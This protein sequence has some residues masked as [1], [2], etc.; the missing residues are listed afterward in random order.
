MIESIITYLAENYFFI[1]LSITIVFILIKAFETIIKR[2]LLKLH[3]QQLKSNNFAYVL[4]RKIHNIRTEYSSEYDFSFLEHGWKNVPFE[5]RNTQLTENNEA[6]SLLKDRIKH[7]NDYYERI[8]KEIKPEYQDAISIEDINFIQKFVLDESKIVTIIDRLNNRRKNKELDMAFIGDKV[9]LYDY[10]I[11]KD[12][13]TLKCYITDHFT[14]KI[15]KELYLDQTKNEDG[16]ESNND[17]F[18]R[19]F[20]S[21]YQNKD[22]ETVKSL[23]MRTLTYIFS[24]MGVDAIVCGK[25]GKNKN[26]CLI[27]I[28][29]SKIDAQKQSRLHVSI[30]E[31]FSET[32]KN[33]EGE[34]D[35][36]QWIIRGLKEEI[37][38]S[39]KNA[40][41]IIP[42]FSDFSIITDNGE[43]GLC[44]TIKTEDIE[45]LQFYPAQDKYLESEGF[46]IAEFPSLIKLYF[47]KICIS[48]NRIGDHFYKKTANEKLRLPWIS[49]APIIFIRTFIRETR[50]FNISTLIIFISALYTLLSSIK[51]IHEIYKSIL[52]NNFSIEIL[53][54]NTNISTIFALVI[55]ILSIISSYQLKKSRGKYKSSIYPW[56]PLWNGN[57][58]P[59]QTTGQ[60]NSNDKDFHNP[61]FGLYFLAS[62]EIPNTIL[63]SSIHLSNTPLCA[64]R[65]LEKMT[66][67]PISF[68][69]ISKNKETGT[70]NNLKFLNIDFKSNETKKTLYFYRIH[71]KRKNNQVHTI[72]SINFPMKEDIIL[73]FNTINNINIRPQNL[74]YYFNLNYSPEELSQN[75]RFSTNLGADL[76]KKNIQLYDLYTYGNNYYWSTTFNASNI[77]KELLLKILSLH[78]LETSHIKGWGKGIQRNDKKNPFYIEDTYIALYDDTN[79]KEEI[80]IDLCKIDA[81][82]DKDF[83][84]KI[85]KFIMHS[86]PCYGG[87]LNELEILALQYILIR[88]DILVAEKKLKPSL[89]ASRIW[90]IFEKPDQFIDS[91]VV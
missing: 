66:E 46:F 61:N 3:E 79:K 59:L 41:D 28:R 15:F 85:N 52:L 70:T 65:K 62:E 10:N 27:T 8:K 30:D 84:L 36:Q 57:A 24:S 89:K 47:K 26:S 68:Y 88:Y 75:Y 35:V 20:L 55:T 16:K 82:S 14:W 44:C 31:A 6:T 39:N 2:T 45:E 76:Y 69:Q 90:K 23:L 73:Q 53:K 22:N 19:L 1:T 83:D 77:F 21:L 81:M 58:K 63:S 48:P 51:S 18:K 4:K 87:G 49:F 64:V 71:I 67:T 25:N 13:I 42:Q 91:L 7:L 80:Q 54:D 9:G 29:S 17:F 11:K 43:I 33:P 50:L 34:Y 38:I 5:N 37:G 78:K 74:I 56:V 86:S 40:K 12:D 60:F 32:D 72:Y